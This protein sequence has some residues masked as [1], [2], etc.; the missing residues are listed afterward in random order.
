MS[1]YKVLAVV[2][3]EEMRLALRQN[4]SKEEEIA[5]VGF[6]AMDTAVLEKIGGYAPHV[7]LL[8]QEKG[9]TGVMDIAER[10]YLGFPGCA[11][12][13]LAPEVDMPLID[14]AMQAG[15][16]RVAGIQDLDNIRDLLIQAAVFEKGR[17]GETGREPHVIAVY[18]G[19][20]G[21]GK[22]TVAVNLAVALAQTGRRT[23][24]IDLCLNF[25]DAALLLNITAK[26]SISDLVQEKSMFAIDDVKSFCIQHSSGVSIL[27]SPSAPEYAEYITPRHVEALISIMR[28]YYDFIVLDLPADLSECT[29]TALEN[30]D[31]ILLVSRMDISNLRA[32][33]LM[34]GVFRSLHQ[35][36]KVLLLLNADH[37]GILKYKDFEQVLEMPASCILPEDVKTVRLSQ[38]RGV[39]FVIGMP[40]TPVSQGV[41]RL[42]SHWIEEKR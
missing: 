10:I 31:D 42:A 41:Q 36:E 19:K 29:L 9:D 8:V 26:D 12:V 25:G 18:G 28:P 2:N 27:C 21:A 14:S 40:R 37:K 16:R 3:S 39:P 13:L 11:L 24:L 30:S 6:A 35:E 38:E 1:K 20:G 7:V 22:T 34:L 4:L 33:K 32:A 15:I 17:T 23:A 5:L